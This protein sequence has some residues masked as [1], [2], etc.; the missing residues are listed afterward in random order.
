MRYDATRKCGVTPL[1]KCI[2]AVRMLAYGIATDC[3]D[4]YLKIG[5]ITALECMKKFALGV[6]EVFGEEYLRKPNQADVDR[7]LKLVIFLVCWEASIAC[8]GS[9]R[10]VQ[11]VGRHHFK[12]N[13]MRCQLSSLK[14]LHYTIFRYGMR[15]SV[16]L[17]VSMK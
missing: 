4:E 12:R 17:E 10:I 16:C 6:I 14:P 8:T 13:F 1:T 2:T 11:R 5:A 9:G 7:L 15:S 3:V